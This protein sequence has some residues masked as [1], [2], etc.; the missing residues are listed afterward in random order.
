MSIPLYFLEPFINLKINGYPNENVLKV[1]F[2]FL[3]FSTL[4]LSCKEEDD[5]SL[6]VDFNS[7]T[8][9]ANSYWNG[10]DNS[11]G[12]KVNDVTFVNAYNT[13]WSSWSGF[14]YA[15][16][17]DVKTAGYGNQYS[18]YALRDSNSANT[19]VVAYPSA[20]ENSIVFDNPVY[21]VK[22]KVTNN[23]YAAL[24]MKYGDAF[25]KKFGGADSTQ[26]DWFKLTIIGI[27]ADNTPTDTVSVY[28][29]DFRFTGKS[30]HGLYS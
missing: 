25:S 28:L 24:S 19:F 7:L 9:S 6:L 2:A 23:S 4:L 21:S 13:S 20:T 26:S 15:N 10:S 8:L 30:K 29:A 22:L 17:H 18:A 27:G 16:M 3:V 11:G 1:T 12:F 5:N 14:A